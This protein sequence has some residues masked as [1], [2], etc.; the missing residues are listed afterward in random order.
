[1]SSKGNADWGNIIKV[2]YNASQSI[3]GQDMASSEDHS[4]TTRSI[5]GTGT[6][7][8][9]PQSLTNDVTTDAHTISA[10][11][12]TPHKRTLSELLDD[13][14]R[15]S[16]V[17]HQRRRT[18]FASYVGLSN[19][20]WQAGTTA[21]PAKNG[22]ASAQGD[23]QPIPALDAPFLSQHNRS[24]AV[25]VDERKHTAPGPSF[26]TTKVPLAIVVSQ[27]RALVSLPPSPAKESFRSPEA[28]SDSSE[29]DKAPSRALHLRS[30]TQ[31]QSPWKVPVGPRKWQNSAIRKDG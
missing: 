17:D 29:D 7:V 4:A 1:M 11:T 19:S 18:G 6:T 5:G 25:W 9:A 13:E 3:E 10:T 26:S 30:N 2:D 15:A 23:F 22:F 28:A 20:A 16:S 27:P 12:E 24:N 8:A 14:Q 31:G 21:G